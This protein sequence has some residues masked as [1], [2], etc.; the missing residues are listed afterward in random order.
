ML[1]AN[2]NWPTRGIYPASILFGSAVEA[3]SSSIILTTHTRTHFSPLGFTGTSHFSLCVQRSFSE[4][5]CFPCPSIRNQVFIFHLAL[6]KRSTYFPWYDPTSSLPPLSFSQAIPTS[7][8]SILLC[9]VNHHVDVTLQRDGFIMNWQNQR[10]I[11]YRQRME[12]REVY[13]SCRS[14]KIRYLSWLPVS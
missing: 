6:R 8:S 9:L 5:I 13:C 14:G 10:L 3:S 7:S 11:V 12:T 2:T 1:K 4:S